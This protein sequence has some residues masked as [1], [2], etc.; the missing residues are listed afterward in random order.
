MRLVLFFLGSLLLLHQFDL[1]LIRVLLQKV[2]GDT[3]MSQKQT[4]QDDGIVLQRKSRAG[5]DGADG[6]GRG[7]IGGNA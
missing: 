7:R 4:S 5:S 6:S 3:P 2:V 1:I